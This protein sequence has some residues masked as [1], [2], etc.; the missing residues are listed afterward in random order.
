MAGGALAL[1]G[2]RKDRVLRQ[3]TIVPVITPV[4]YCMSAI[5]PLMAVALCLSAFDCIVRRGQAILCSAPVITAARGHIQVEVTEQD[6]RTPW[7]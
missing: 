4:L 7:F 2:E 3:V 1:L 5:A 6:G